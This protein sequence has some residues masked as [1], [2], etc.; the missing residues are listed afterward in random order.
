TGIQPDG[1]EVF[2]RDGRAFRFPKWTIEG[3]LRKGIVDRGIYRGVR[4]P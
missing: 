2:A 4:K 1:L 3:I